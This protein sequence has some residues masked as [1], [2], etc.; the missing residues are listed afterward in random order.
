VVDAMPQIVCVV[1]PD[2]SP[3]YVNLAWTAFSGLDLEATARAGWAGFVHPDDFGAV[4]D[5]RLR[6]LKTRAPQQVELRYRAADGTYHWFLSRLAPIVEGGRVVR[7]VG[8]ALDIQ[9]RKRAEAALRESEE[10]ARVSEDRARRQLAEIE[11]IYVSAPVGLCVFDRDLRWVRLNERAAEIDGHPLEAHIGKT[12]RDLLPSVGEQA[13]AALRKILDTGAPLLD[14]EIAGTTPAQPG[15]TR[16]W[17]ERWVPIKDREGCVLGVSVAVEE[18]TQRK[19]AE[20]ELRE[21]NERLRDADRRKDEFLGM[22]SHE[23]RNPLAPI[24]N[25]LYV[26]ERADPAG[27]QARRAKDV[28][29]RQLSHITRLVDDLLDVTRIARG[30][31]ELRRTD[32]NLAALA[33]E[34]AD[35][36]RALMKERGLELALDVPCEAVVVNGDHAR[37]AQ[38]LGNLVNNA[39]KFTPA[40]GR[41]T[42]TVRAEGRHAVVHVQDTGPGIE[43]QMLHSIFEPFTQAKQTLARSEGG[44]GLGLALV[45]GLV[46][47]HRGEV[48]AV[49]GGA[50]QG[51]DFVVRIP[52]VSVPRASV[53]EGNG[54]ADARPAPRRRRVLVVDDNR[55]AAE[56][57]AQLLEMLGHDTEVAYDGPSAIAKARRSAPDVILCDI[58]LPGMD[59]YE[60]ARQIRSGGPTDV[61]LV[62][63]SGYAQPDDVAKAVEAGF[64]GHVAKPPDPEKLAHVIH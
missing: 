14:F 22:L 51:T 3:E 9:D 27:P 57:L 31:I 52:L 54:A 35:D 23:L 41:V 59:G 45:R 18:I 11:A 30:K 63:V 25:A 46:T 38:V 6:A 39:A 53:V 48:T 33:R 62:A 40:G 4:C 15:V 21:A 50:G 13:E 55:D 60:V 44:L 10:Q 32:V 1:E 56:T 42:L 17:N 5:C 20:A 19:R 29:V 7:F 49:S 43:P 24:R 34:T 28:A 58:G 61:R 8:A 36:H 47:L 12:P 64:D 37:L 2:G 16:F 26:L